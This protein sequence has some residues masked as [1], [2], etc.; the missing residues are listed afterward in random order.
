MPHAVRLTD[1]SRIY[2]SVPMPTLRLL[3]DDLT[4]A[5]DSAAEFV[6]LTGPIP[7]FWPGV[8]PPRF[9]ASAAIDSGTR[10]LSAV[11]AVGVVADL[12]EHLATADIAFKKIDSLFR[13]PTLQEIAATFSRGF[14]QSCVL[15]PAFPHQ[16]RIT[17]D[18]RQY[19]RGDDGVT[20]VSVHLPDALCDLG[21]MACAGTLHQPLRPG[22]NV[23]D[24]D[25]DVTLEAVVRTGTRHGAPLLWI[26]TGGLAR[27]LTGKQSHRSVAEPLPRPILG[28]FGSDH[29]VMLRQLE[30]CQ[31]F[32]TQVNHDRIDF[33]NVKLSHTNPVLMSLLIPPETHRAD[34]AK[35]IASAIG[36]L[37]SAVDKPGTIIVAGGET[38]RELCTALGA[39]Y[40]EVTGALLP[41]VPRSIVRGG[42]WD[43]VTVVSKSGAFGAPDLL[44]QL[45][46]FGEL[47]S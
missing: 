15:A 8:F 42:Q 44:R 47:P 9:P 2:T 32:W 37:C 33:A 26:G 23:F 45:P 16:G 19:V 22:I 1:N 30:A 10:E 12:V 11:A 7:V 28:L 40:L 24:A 5:L 46:I 27:A 43:G 4:G 6:P 17:R 14:W 25:T 29:P 3:A 36:Y 13:G 21:V 31:T 20:A 38:L 39:A 18:G 35:N 34:A 41:G